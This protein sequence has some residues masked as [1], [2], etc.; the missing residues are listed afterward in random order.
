ME[1][2]TQPDLHSEDSVF[3]K[4]FGEEKK[5]QKATQ[6]ERTDR[7]FADTKAPEYS[8][9]VSDFLPSY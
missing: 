8:L 3:R 4:L 7:V 1:N 9:K 6:A 2:T 5:P